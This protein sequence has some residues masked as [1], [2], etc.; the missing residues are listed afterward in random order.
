[1]SGY[2][3]R[4]AS[5][6]LSP[7]RA[8]HPMVGSM[9]AAPGKAEP[10][11]TILGEAP[12]DA[13]PR[14]STMLRGEAAHAKAAMSDKASSLDVEQSET[15]PIR[16]ADLLIEATDRS[17]TAEPVRGGSESRTSPATPV[18]IHPLLAADRP[19]GVATELKS[20][21]RNASEFRE[22]GAAEQP[23]PAERSAPARFTPLVVSASPNA[24]DSIRVLHSPLGTERRNP[25]SLTTT[26]A[27]QE[28]DEIQIHIGRIE[29][30]AA[31]PQPPARP[32]AKP[33]S[34]VDLGEYLKRDRRAR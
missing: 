5:G 34:S 10:I 3:Q 28:P 9:W 18:A 4:I 23:G 21:R 19:G 7:A 2:L 15:G 6:V 16:S 30:T 22:A 14:R 32:A 26:Q 29:V 25:A 17:T 33:R 13:G 8:I 1:M 31:L 24:S 11:E 20:Q 27:A 12:T